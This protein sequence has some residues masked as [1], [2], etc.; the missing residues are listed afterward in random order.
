MAYGI[1]RYSLRAQ[2]IR[3]A[4]GA[5]TKVSNIPTRSLKRDEAAVLSS[6][7]EKVQAAQKKRKAAQKA[8]LQN[9][10]KAKVR[11]PRA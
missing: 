3:N 10:I 8:R 2:L 4:K 1:R 9:K 5:A 11:S 6:Q 7:A